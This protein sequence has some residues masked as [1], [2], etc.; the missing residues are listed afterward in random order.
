MNTTNSTQCQCIICVHIRLYQIFLASH[1]L[2]PFVS[3]DTE[4]EK[5]GRPL[6]YI[7]N[8]YSDLATHTVVQF[9][10]LLNQLALVS[11]IYV[12]VVYAC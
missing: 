7:L 9:S 4:C 3:H 2:L 11:H 12:Y 6:G 1:P 8:A 5:G 10:R